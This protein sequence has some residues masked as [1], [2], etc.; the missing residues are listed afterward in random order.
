M[1]IEIDSYNSQFHKRIIFTNESNKALAN[2]LV[3]LDDW[4]VKTAIQLAEKEN[5]HNPLEI[6]IEDRHILTIKQKLQDAL[7]L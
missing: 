7:H 6:T 2:L 3:K 4:I 5:P 1:N